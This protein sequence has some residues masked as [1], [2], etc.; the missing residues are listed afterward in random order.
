MV[1]VQSILC[2]IG[3]LSGPYREIWTGLGG[4][5]LASSM[6]T[7]TCCVIIIPIPIIINTSSGLSLASNLYLY[8]F[9]TLQVLGMKK[10]AGLLMY[11]REV[12]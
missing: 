6:S 7:I 2:N 3:P 12:T 8:D 4:C 10:V 1:K 9:V 11:P 5:R